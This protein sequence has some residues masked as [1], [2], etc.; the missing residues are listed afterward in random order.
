MKT[1]L[2]TE[3]TEDVKGVL[4]ICKYNYETTELKVTRELIFDNAR[5]ALDYYCEIPNPESQLATETSQ[6][7]LEHELMELHKNISDPQW[8]IELGEQL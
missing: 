1:L 2:G 4:Y 5:D 3:L 7:T 6:H 8:R